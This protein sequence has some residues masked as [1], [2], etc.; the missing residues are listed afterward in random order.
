MKVTSFPIAGLLLLEPTVHGDP[1]GFFMETFHAARYREAGIS[2]AFVQDNLSRSSR[3]VLRGLHFQV[4][5]PQAKLIQAL[6]GEIYDVAVDLRR[7]SATFGKWAGVSLSERNHHQFFI[8]EGFA[9]GFCV[10]GDSALVA[11]KCS[12]LYDPDDEAGIFWA[13]PDLAIQWPTA[14]PAVSEKDARLP[15]LS[16]CPADRLPWAAS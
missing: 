12:T 5:R 1:R 11:Y 7:D 2:A 13:D 3:G 14:A 10:V 4:R 15:R 8:P 16:E 6:Q 9:H